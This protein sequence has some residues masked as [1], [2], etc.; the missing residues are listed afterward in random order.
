MGRVRVKLAIKLLVTAFLLWVALRAVDVTVVTDVLSSPNPLWVAAA[1][2]LTLLIITADGLL[3]ATVLPMFDR[4]VPVRTAM[5]Y[6]MV[7][8][9][10]SNVAPSTVGGDLYRGVQL[11]RAGIPV[12]TAVRAVL[13]IRL[14][15]LATLILVMIAGLPIAVRV[16]DDRSGLI[17]ILTALGMAIA[18]LLGLY[19]FD[20]LPWTNSFLERWRLLEKVKAISIDFRRMVSATPQAKAAWGEAA[21]QHI[22]RVGVIIA[23]AAALGLDIPPETL[24]A[25]TP[26][27]LLVAMIP[28]SFGGWGV[29]EVS[30]VYLLGTAGVDATSALVLSVAF[31]LLRLAVGAIGGVLWVILGDH[32]FRLSSPPS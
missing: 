17:V 23:L 1:T 10:F 21:I 9:F 2:I 8:W 14:L 15:S 11:S 4:H 3:L 13:S 5:L 22:L 18:A 25:L 31:G 28:V 30:F 16:I 29:R 19:L 32:H 27:A 24:F 7:G 26:A 20:R 12:G 6:S